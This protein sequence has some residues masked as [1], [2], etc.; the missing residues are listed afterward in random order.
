MKCWRIHNV[1][2]CMC[3]SLGV[4]VALP[5]SCLRLHEYQDERRGDESRGLKLTIILWFCGGLGELASL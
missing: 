2:V 1:T 5:S 3:K 4:I